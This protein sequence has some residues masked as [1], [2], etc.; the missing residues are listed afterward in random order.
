M[1]NA[2]AYGFIG[3]LIALGILG[4][5]FYRKSTTSSDFMLAGRSLGYWTTAIAAHASDMSIWMFMGLPAA[6]YLTGLKS[7]LIPLGLMAGMYLTWLFIAAPLRIATEKLQSDTLSTYFQKRFHDSSGSLRLISAF[8]SLWFFTFY[9]ASGLVGMGYLFKSVFE[10]DYHTG[11]L[12]G[13]LITIGYTLLGGFAAIAQ[14]HFFQGI[15]VVIMM[16]LV[17]ALAFAQLP[18]GTVMHSFTAHANSF[19]PHSFLSLCIPIIGALSWGM[20]YFGQ[21]HILVNFMG[22]KDPKSMPKAMRV[23]MLWQLFTFSSSVL[24]GLIGIVFFTTPLENA[25]LVFI[26]MATSVFPA[27]IAGCILCSIVAAGL[28]TIATQMLVAS[29][30]IAHDVY[31]NYINKNASDRTIIRVSQVALIIIPLFSYLVAFTGFS[32]VFDLV[33]YAWM[34]LGASFGPAIIA[35]LYVPQA[36]TKGVIRGMLAGGLTALIWPLITG[37]I[38]AL[39][40]AFLINSIFILKTDPQ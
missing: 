39:I 17:P 12:I 24:A 28:T 4:A 34:G 30:T 1:L 8:L 40:P 37:I 22:I 31:V 38:P 16:I 5:V 10:I 36:S 35:A 7:I 32:T 2:F 9:I 18:I 15:F 25:Q 29:S 21:P 6:V 27:F 20:G 19:I 26:K 14:S 11:I 23:G 13:L 3:Y 33:E